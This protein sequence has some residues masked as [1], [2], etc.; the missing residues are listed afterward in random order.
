MLLSEYSIKSK[1][2]KMFANQKILE[3][4]NVKIYEIDPYFYKKYIE[5]IKADKNGHE[6]I[7]FRIDVYFCK[8][9][10]TVEVDEKEHTDRDLI[11]ERKRQEALK[12]NSIANLLELIL[13]KKVMMYFMKL[14][15]H[16]Y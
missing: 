13:I 9:N 16:T 8:Y 15:E 10:L 11:F 12:K 3:E 2:G 14:V 6:Y 7:R 5:K 4:Y 1:I